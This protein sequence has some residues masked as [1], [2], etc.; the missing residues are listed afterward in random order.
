M[1]KIVT[2]LADLLEQVVLVLRGQRM[3]DAQPSSA[4]A[5]PDLSVPPGLARRSLYGFKMA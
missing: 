2:Q 4:P 3:Q 5:F 1:K